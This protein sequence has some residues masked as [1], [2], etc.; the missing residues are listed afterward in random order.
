MTILT[1]PE[2]LPDSELVRRQCAEVDAASQKIQRERERGGHAAIRASD[3]FLAAVPELMAVAVA[4]TQRPDD[5]ARGIHGGEP[6]K[7]ESF[8]KKVSE[9]TKRKLAGRR[10]LAKEKAENDARY[11]RKVRQRTSGE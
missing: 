6:V 1:H 5:R 9:A 11:L 8:E 7:A 3:D 10:D 2:P 4:R